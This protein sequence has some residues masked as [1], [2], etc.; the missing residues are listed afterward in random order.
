MQFVTSNIREAL[1]SSAAH[2][3]TVLAGNMQ[4]ANKFFPSLK[5][6]DKPPSP[7]LPKS[8]RTLTI[9][10]I[11]PLEVARQVRIQSFDSSFFG[12]TSELSPL[13]QLTIIDFEIFKQ[14]SPKEFFKLGWSK[15]DS[16][17]IAP[18]ITALIHRS[19]QVISCPFKP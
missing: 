13:I 2:I 5:K 19:T 9:L 8:L 12:R 7:V 15:K 3:E 18:N 16:Q 14:I 11:D 17:Y 6:D 10:A 1:P 4:P